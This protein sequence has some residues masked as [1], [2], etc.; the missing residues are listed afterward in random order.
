MGRTELQNGVSLSALIDQ[1]AGQSINGAH[2]FGSGYS[3]SV[4]G[5][6]GGYAFYEF[7]GHMEYVGE[8]YG[9][10]SL[11][12]IW[13]TT[14]EE[15]LEYLNI[16]EKVVVND[17]LAY[18]NLVL[19][20]DETEDL[21]TD[22]RYYAISIVVEADAVIEEIIIDGGT[23]NTYK[24][25]GDTTALLNLNWDGYV[26]VADTVNAEFYV[27][28]AESSQ[29]QTDW[30][31]AMDYVEIL[32]SG[33]TKEY[34]RDRLCAIQGII[35]PDGYCFAQLLPNLIQQFALAIVLIL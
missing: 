28:K 25:I 24:G 17:A 8:V 15:I 32:P 4:T 22:F 31:I 10:D 30:N 12:N 6:N 9:K 29:L 14:E 34:F 13:M 20:F 5:Q 16:N 3:N 2:H 26:E 35:P 19:T 33:S 23:N 7:T 18:K 21:P 27:S 11:D 1:I